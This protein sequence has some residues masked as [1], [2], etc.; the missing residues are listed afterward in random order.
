MC[1]DVELIEQ[2]AT[3]PSRRDPGQ[4]AYLNPAYHPDEGRPA[5]TGTFWID[6]DYDRDRASDGISRY[7]AYVRD[8]RHL[9]AEIW[10]GTFESSLTE[11]FAALAWQI[12]TGPVMSPGYV[13]RHSRVIGAAVEVSDW[14]GALIAAVDLV[15]PQPGPLRWAR[16]ATGGIWRDWPAD[17]LAGPPR[18]YEPSGQDLASS[19]YLLAS[20][21]L[22][23]TVPPGR[24][25]HPPAGP[26]N[27]RHAL[28]ET[29][30]DAVRE[31]AGELNQILDPVIETL[32]RS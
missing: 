4:R 21:S 6:H 18:Y 11:R 1:A 23:F 14:D 10:D 7:G 22:R 5:M 29:A 27:A 26:G 3:Y 25:P 12:A 9:F 13:R 28:V 19:P 31:L 30:R 8:R 15:I 32:E 16:V 24:L 2:S 17:T 20:A